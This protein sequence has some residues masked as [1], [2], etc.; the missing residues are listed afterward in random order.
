MVIKIFKYLMLMFISIVVGTIVSILLFHTPLFANIHVLMYRGIVLIMIT[1]MLLILL[2]LLLKK[3]MRLE[4]FDGKD[5]LN[6]FIAFVC[7]NMVFFTLVPVTVE[8]SVSVFTLSQM[9][10]AENYTMTKE[11]AENIF[12]SVYVNK[13]DAFG[14]RFD[15]QIVTGSIVDNGD[16]SYTLTDRGHA[17][18]NMF[19]FIGKLYNADC[20]NLY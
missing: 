8:R 17:L 9:E 1:G 5:I 6:I 11:E 18:V 12:N 16:G 14:K 20:K 19:R 2:L 13:N 4:F 10:M 3:V 15:E 7:V